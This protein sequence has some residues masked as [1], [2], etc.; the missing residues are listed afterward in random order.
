MPIARTALAIVAALVSAWFALG[1]VQAHDTSRA[2]AIV[3]GHALLPA[4]RAAQARSLLA[5]AA[6]LN[7]DEQVNLLSAQIELDQ[8]RPAAAA[9]ILRGVAA[10]EP[11]N[12]GA[13]VLL[14]RASY[15]TKTV[16]A[17]VRELARLD[18]LDAARR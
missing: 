13:W 7:P 15:G 14:A 8:R 6:T 3:A 4:E 1:V 5:T 9:R 2:Q 18:P 12:I 11:D 10:R 16:T 17:V